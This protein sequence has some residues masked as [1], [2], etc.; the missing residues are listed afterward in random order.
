MHGCDGLVIT[1]YDTIG[2][3]GSNMGYR[4]TCV[5]Y[6]LSDVAE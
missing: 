3:H 2:S 1:G 4:G 6:K 5:V